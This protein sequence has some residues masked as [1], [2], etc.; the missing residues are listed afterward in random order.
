MIRAHL[1]YQQTM[2]SYLDL[3]KDV[4]SDLRVLMKNN[5][6]SDAAVVKFLVEYVL[7]EK[8]DEETIDN[9]LNVLLKYDG[10]ASIKSNVV[11]F[12]YNGPV[13]DEDVVWLLELACIGQR[14]YRVSMI[15]A[16]LNMKFKSFNS[17]FRLVVYED[18]PLENAPKVEIYRRELVGEIEYY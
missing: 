15:A 4:M 18:T 1:L 16:C 7:E 6:S 10:K 3:S 9:C 11:D 17:D 2:S 14:S 12:A 13:E 8:D 5:L